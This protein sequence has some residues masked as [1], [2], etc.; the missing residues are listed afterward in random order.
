MLASM[1][2]MFGQS[3]KPFCSLKL[4]VSCPKIYQH[5]NNALL[6]FFRNAFEKILIDVF[7]EAG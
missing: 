1:E 4:C 3:I 5:F 2:G 7:M 6:P